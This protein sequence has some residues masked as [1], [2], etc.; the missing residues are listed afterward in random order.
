MSSPNPD[1]HAKVW[2]AFF[3]DDKW[4]SFAYAKGWNPIPI[5]CDLPLRV[6]VKPHGVLIP[7]RHQGLQLAFSLPAVVV[8][9]QTLT[10][11]LSC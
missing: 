4:L 8:R 1:K 10:E 9:A 7:S 3:K 11:I 2:N 5:G 6:R